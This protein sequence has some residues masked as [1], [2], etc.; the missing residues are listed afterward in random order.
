VVWVEP[1]FEQAEAVRVRVE[2]A[3]RDVTAIGVEEY[4]LLVDF[5]ILDEV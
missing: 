3:K 4:M 2:R 5:G 1:C